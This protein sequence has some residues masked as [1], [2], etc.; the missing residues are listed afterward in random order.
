MKIF[1]E[2]KRM[3]LREIVPSD[4]ESIF[5]LDSDPEV[6][7]YLAIPPMH[8]LSQAADIITY[9]RKQYK[10]NGIGRWAMVLKES[11]EF[12]GWCG[13]KFV[14]DSVVN[15]QTNYY[16][17]GYR[18]MSKRWGEGLATEAAKACMDY[19]MN[20]LKLDQIHGTVRFENLASAHVLRKLGLTKVDDFADEHGF[21]WEWYSLIIKRDAADGSV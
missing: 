20:V 15:G 3:I 2:T 6:G 21:M 1:A 5:K 19:A 16:D 17:I 18:L 12:V 7:R 10:E 13:I 11:N 9:I 8:D 4:K 14:N